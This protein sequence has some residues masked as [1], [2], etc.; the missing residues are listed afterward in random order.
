[1]IPNKRMKSGFSAIVSVSHERQRDDYSIPCLFDHY[2]SQKRTGLS[3]FQA[4]FR[5][6][7]LGSSC[8]SLL[9]TLIKYCVVLL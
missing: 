8:A 5:G 9:A 3:S 4:V 2:A 7:L 1:M 6:W